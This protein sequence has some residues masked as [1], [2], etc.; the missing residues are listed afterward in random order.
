MQ[1][2]RLTSLGFLFDLTNNSLPSMEVLH[3]NGTM[4]GINALARHSLAPM[5]PEGMDSDL[6]P[7]VGSELAMFTCE[8]R[9][10][11]C[12]PLGP[13]PS[14]WIIHSTFVCRAHQPSGNMSWLSPYPLHPLTDRSNCHVTRGVRTEREETDI[15]FNGIN[16]CTMATLRLEDDRNE[17]IRSMQTNPDK[18]FRS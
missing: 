4:E 18:Q 3:A 15:M 8:N 10:Q 1:N 5:H 13:C 12:E 2:N 11:F 16:P 7:S 14:R 6:L 17:N 9:V